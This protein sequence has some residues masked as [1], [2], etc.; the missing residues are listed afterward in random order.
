MSYINHLVWLYMHVHVYTQEIWHVQSIFQRQSIFIVHSMRNLCTWDVAHVNEIPQHLSKDKSIPCVQIKLWRQ[1][2]NKLLV[3]SIAGN[4]IEQYLMLF[5]GIFKRFVQYKPNF[6]SFT[7]G[8]IIL[9]N[10]SKKK[11]NTVDWLIIIIN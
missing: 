9:C 6:S 11:A 10:F 5:Y 4:W 1:S 3:G 2:P 7:F 8:F